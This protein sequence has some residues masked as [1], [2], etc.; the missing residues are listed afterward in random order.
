MSSA[1][2]T[3]S[4]VRFRRSL[5]PP[6]MLGAVLNPINSSIIAIA[7]VPIA[8]AFGAPASETAWLVSSLYL[9]TAVGQ[10]LTGRLIDRF[11]PKRLFL[12]GALLVLAAGIIGVTATGLQALIVARVILGFGTCAGYPSAMYLIRAESARTGLASPAGVLAALSIAT[13]T[14]SVIGPTLGGALIHLGGWRMTFGINIPLGI[15]SFVLGFFALPWRTV[16]DGT[17][18]RRR[19]DYLGTVLFAGAMTALMLL[20]MNIGTGTLWLLAVVAVAGGAMVWWEL[21][22]SEPFIDVRVFGGNT[23]LLMT[24]VRAVLAGTVS[25]CYLYGFTQWLEDGRGLTPAVAG[26]VLIPTFGIGILVAAFAGRK[27]AVQGM[28]RVGSGAQFAVSVLLLTLTH[29]D[30]PVWSIILITAVMGL[31][32][33]LVNL[34]NQNAMYYQSDPE[35][36]GASAGLLRTFMYLGAMLAA[37]ATHLFFPAGA[38]SSG[39][40]DLAWA[41]I[42]AS[43]I[44]LV[45]SVADRSLAGIGKK[46]DGQKAG[47]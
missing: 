8:A 24:F 4:P 13:Q 6:L 43:G 47:G 25:Y 42:A 18:P 39:L 17:E 22:H 36:T 29:D 30:S 28:L 40:H 12:I 41:M 11:G 32:Q 1:A 20:L 19:F 27:G 37:A 34:A 3:T 15:A 23:P 45:M 44:L 26:T 31:P 10:P 16:L 14:I 7:L 33:G 9:A 5:L 35:R 21:R 46:A 2:T 38:T